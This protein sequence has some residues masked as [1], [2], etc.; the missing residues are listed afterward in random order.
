MRDFWQEAMTLEQSG[1]SFVTA[2]LISTRGHA[3]QDP[4]A[5]ILITSQ[6]RHWGTIGGGKLEAHVI[7]KG[8][9]LLMKSEPAPVL[10]E[11]NL[12]SDIGM[13]C[14]GVVHIL[15]E[16]HRPQ[17][18]Q[19]FIFGAGHIAQALVRTLAPLACRIEVFDE[20]REWLERIPNERNVHTH[21]R[22]A[23]SEV[24][25][26]LSPR[27]Y[28]LVMTKGHASDLPVLNEIFR[29]HS[30]APY[31]GVIGSTVKA[32]KIKNDLIKLGHSDLSLTKL[33]SPMGLKLGGNHPYEIAIS[34]AAEILQT[35][36]RENFLRST[37]EQSSEPSECDSEPTTI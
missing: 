27:G 29:Y 30:Q 23:C 6:G 14:G 9:A 21:S 20:R 32:R 18:W 3:P 22:I 13:S 11:W 4:G 10:C 33:H 1:E 17:A 34:I 26:S 24:V 7:E 15:F 28:F 12:A 37:N 5:K 16:L 31:I 36:D 8:R 19:I 25:R 35:R 2:T